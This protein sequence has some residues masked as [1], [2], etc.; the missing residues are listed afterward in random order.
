MATNPERRCTARRTNGEPCKCRPIAG[1]TV[2]RAH[3]GA[4]PQVRE[5]ARRR[6][7]ELVDPA[8]ATIHRSLTRKYKPGEHPTAVELAAAREILNRAAISAGPDPSPGQTDQPGG[9]WE[10]FH[11]I[12]RRHTA[13]EAE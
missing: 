3:G 9:T 5:A 8:L 6:L 13:P 1:A 11:Q 2:C 10:E 12:Y 7:L 4:A